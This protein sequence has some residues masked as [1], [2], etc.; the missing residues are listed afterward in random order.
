MSRLFGHFSCGISSFDWRPQQAY[1]FRPLRQ[2]DKR[3]HG[4]M[5]S[6][7]SAPYAAPLIS[8]RPTRVVEVDSEADEG[9][10]ASAPVIELTRLRPS[11]LCWVRGPMI[12]HRAS[13][14]W[15]QI[16]AQPF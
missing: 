2:G 4:A 8:Y 10:R 12:R 14:S 11:R 7:A 1:A 16:R 3:M 9:T 6:A 5:T 13:A 15:L